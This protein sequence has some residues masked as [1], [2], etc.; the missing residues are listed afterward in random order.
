MFK[1]DFIQQL[2]QLLISKVNHFSLAKISTMLK[3]K[4]TLQP[5]KPIGPNTLIKA[6][7]Q[8]SRCLPDIT[9]F[10]CNNWKV[11]LFFFNKQGIQKVS[12]HLE[13]LE[14]V[15]GS[16]VKRSDAC[17]RVG[18]PVIISS[19]WLCLEPVASFHIVDR[20]S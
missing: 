19:P 12:Q 8:M 17:I 13:T 10:M 6:Q 14:K 11:F 3:E 16:F 2:T 9:P 7:L 5:W 18:S 4:D 1:E 20:N 15:N